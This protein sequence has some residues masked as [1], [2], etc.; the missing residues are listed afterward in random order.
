MLNEVCKFKIQFINSIQFQGI[1]YLICNCRKRSGRKQR[2]MLGG[3]K[4]SK[5]Q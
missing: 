3:Q 1:C 2:V 5:S 4:C